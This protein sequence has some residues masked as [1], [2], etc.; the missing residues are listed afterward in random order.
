MDEGNQLARPVASSMS[1]S[2]PDT[3]RKPDYDLPPYPS[4]Q[5]PNT[6]DHPL[7]PRARFDE[8]NR[9]YNRR[10]I[11]LMDLEEFQKLVLAIRREQR[12]YGAGKPLEAILQGRMRNRTDELEGQLVSVK[13][14]VFLDID[15]PTE[16]DALTPFLGDASHDSTRYMIQTLKL[17]SRLLKS[18][19]ARMQESI[20]PSQAI[21]KSQDTRMQESV[22]LSRECN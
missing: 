9:K 7:L 15:I 18:Q 4:T 1:I 14:K 5:M 3:V 16:L 13:T 22:S 8:I 10:S 21:V 17:I 2:A 20:P 11:P 6:F 12:D 19:D